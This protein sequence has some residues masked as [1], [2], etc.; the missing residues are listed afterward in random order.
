MFIDQ[1]AKFLR[2]H[3]KE[4]ES[5]ELKPLNTSPLLRME[6]VLVLRFVL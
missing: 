1:G 2:L 6:S 5:V 3:S 4:R